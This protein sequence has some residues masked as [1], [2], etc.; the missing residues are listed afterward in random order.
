MQASRPCLLSLASREE[1]LV[2]L[3][4]WRRHAQGL[5]LPLLRMCWVHAQAHH[6]LLLWC[7]LQM[8]HQHGDACTPAAGAAAAGCWCLLPPFYYEGSTE[9]AM[10][11]Q[12]C[13]RSWVWRPL[14]AAVPPAGSAS[15]WSRLH[16]SAIWAAAW[17]ACKRGPRPLAPA[18]AAASAAARRSALTCCLPAGAEGKCRGISL[19]W[20]RLLLAAGAY[21]WLALPFLNGGSA[22]AAH[23]AQ[24]CTGSRCCSLEIWRM[25]H[26][27]TAKLVDACRHPRRAAAAGFQFCMLSLSSSPTGPTAC[28]PAVTAVPPVAA[29]SAC[30]LRY[31]AIWEMR[32]A[33]CL[34]GLCRGAL[35]TGAVRGVAGC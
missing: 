1:S 13:V 31:A 26:V 6:L 10:R 33:G 9:A 28:A 7:H 32:G 12:A 25:P 3:Q 18:G 5:L 17:A 14:G 23:W 20:G 19:L 8:L 16:A 11:V 22:E 24:A 4:S 15:A 35:A 29:A 30:S 2:W 21:W 27:H 34:C